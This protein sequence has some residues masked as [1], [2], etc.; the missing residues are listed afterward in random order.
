MR[1]RSRADRVSLRPL[2]PAGE[3]FGRLAAMVIVDAL[4]TGVFLA[5]SAVC[6]TRFVGLSASQL[7]LGLLLGGLVGLLTTVPWGALADRVGARRVLI[8]LTLW[9][10]AGFAAYALV[11]SFAAF[12][13]VTCLLGV[14]DRAVAPATQAL[15]GA[16][17]ATADRVRTMA[18]LRA[19]RNVGFG[20]A[21]VMAGAALTFDGRAVL[22]AIVLGNAASFV[23]VAAIVASLP[24]P[25]PPATTRAKAPLAAD[26]RLWALTTLNALL[27]VHMTLLS[28]GVPLLI[29]GHTSVTPAAMGPLLTLNTVL[30][31][32][33]QVR[34]SRGATDVEGAGRCLRRAGAALAATCILLAAATVAPLALAV[35]LLVA[36]IITLTAGELL[37]SAGAW[38]LSFELAPEARQG[39]YLSFFSLGTTVQVIAGPLLVAG[40]LAAGAA[41]WAALALLLVAAGAATPAVAR[42]ASIASRPA[43]AAAAG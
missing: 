22:D 19:L 16:R 13:V 1:T 5:G 26:R 40:V 8:A 17:V 12:V 23:V 39:A 38:G 24:D 14:A 21:G 30:A 2:V 37:Q 18:A 3:P 27:S 36:G 28:V 15:I 35:A 11:D 20:G 33:L 25:R 34:A 29:A 7:G 10:A 32:A 43:V 42:R 6:F 41:G 9:R 4:G 31:V